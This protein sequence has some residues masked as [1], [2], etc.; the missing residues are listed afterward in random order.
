MKILIFFFCTISQ[1]RCPKVVEEILPIGESSPEEK[2][3]LEK[4]KDTSKKDIRKGV[5]F[6]GAK[7]V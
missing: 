4:C 2:V 7:D 5:D 3:L 1:S 6:V